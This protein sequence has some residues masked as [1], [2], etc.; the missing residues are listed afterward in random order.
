MLFFL[1]FASALL[2]AVLFGAH[3]SLSSLVLSHRRSLT[4]CYYFRERLIPLLPLRLQSYLRNYAP[5]ASFDA[6]L[7][8]GYSSGNFDLRSNVEGHDGRSGMDDEG[9]AQVRRLMDRYGLSFDEVRT[10]PFFPPSFEAVSWSE[11]VTGEAT[12][13]A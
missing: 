7:E 5:L 10:T 4:V 8:A 2:A 11:C 3:L 1:S 6:A 13:A 12:A 9:L